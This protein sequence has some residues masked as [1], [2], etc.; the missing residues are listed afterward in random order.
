MNGKAIVLDANILIRAVL[1]Q[2]PQVNPAADRGLGK[3]LFDRRMRRSELGQ[4]AQA[5]RALTG[6]DKSEG[7]DHRPGCSEGTRI[8]RGQRLD[9]LYRGVGSRRSTVAQERRKTAT[10]LAAASTIP[11]LARLP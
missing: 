4:H 2:R 6:K 8:I 9:R 10:K 11:E 1:G 3:T 7:L 5:L